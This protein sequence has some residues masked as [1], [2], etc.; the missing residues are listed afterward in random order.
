VHTGR[1][2][3]GRVPIPFHSQPIAHRG[4]CG[5]TGVVPQNRRPGPIPTGNGGYDMRVL[6]ADVW[7]ARGRRTDGW[8]CAAVAGTW[9][10]AA[11]GRAAGP[12]G[13]AGR[14]ELMT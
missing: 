11:G 2:K 13:A 10:A 4:A 3:E 6:L 8:T 7:V 5:K 9:R 1:W 14:S 12:R